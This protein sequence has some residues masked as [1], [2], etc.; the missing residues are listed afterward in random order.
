MGMHMEDSRIQKLLFHFKISSL[1]G[2]GLMRHNHTF[3]MWTGRPRQDPLVVHFLVS[4]LS[5][6]MGTCHVTSWPPRRFY[7]GVF[8]FSIF[9][10]LFIMPASS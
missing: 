6:G 4:T 7:H 5:L 8:T 3:F 10:Y 1:P 9:L 2:L